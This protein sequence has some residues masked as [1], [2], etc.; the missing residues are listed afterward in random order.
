MFVRLGFSVAIHTDPE[1]LLVDEVLAVGDQAFQQRCLKRLKDFQR[2]G[3][4]I[5]L[6]SHELQMIQRLC[7]RVLWLDNGK[8]Q[9]DGPAEQITSTYANAVQVYLESGAGAKG[10]HPQG[11]SE[12]KI[13]RIIDVKIL[14]AEGKPQWVFQSGQPLRVHIVYECKGLVEKPVFSILIHRSD[15]LYVS[16]T[17]TFNIDP[18]EVGPIKGRGVMVVDINRLDLYEGDYFLSVGAYLEPDPPFWSKP[19]DFLDK[20]YRLRVISP[21]GAHGVFILPAKWEHYEEGGVS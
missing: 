10:E 20:R 8:V 17:N 9:A 12:Q 15:G 2:E 1:I 16:S 4:T 3:R 14:D 13:L 19:A 11:S 5:M 21:K 6:V 18:I 7:A